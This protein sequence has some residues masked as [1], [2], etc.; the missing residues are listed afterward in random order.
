MKCH[1]EYERAEP[2]ELTILSDVEKLKTVKVY[3]HEQT[4]VKEVGTIPIT[5]LVLKSSIKT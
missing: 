1:G 2:V 4:P 5:I 3:Y